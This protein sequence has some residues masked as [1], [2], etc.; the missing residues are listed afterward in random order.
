[1]EQDKNYLPSNVKVLRE[2]ARLSVQEFAHLA[3][4]SAETVVG[5]EKG[6]I[7]VYTKDLIVICPILRISEEDIRERDIKQERLDAYDRMKHG[8]SRKNFDWYYGSK[9]K[10]IFY[11]LPIILIPL[12]ALIGYLFS[13]SMA[14]YYKEL[15]DLWVQSGNTGSNFLFEYYYLIYPL[16]AATICGLVFIIIEVIKRFRQYLKWWYILIGLSFSSV[17]LFIAGVA[18]IPFYIYCVYQVFVL[19]GK[20]RK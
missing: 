11:L 10:V 15:N 13:L 2:E 19:K 7:K 14:E 16:V 8:N 9:S 6:T 12:A 4:V 17:L 20:N 1:M 5:W 3:N 18:V